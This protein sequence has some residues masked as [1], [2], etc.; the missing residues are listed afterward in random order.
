MLAQLGVKL[1]ADISSFTGE[2]KKASSAIDSFGNKVAGVGKIVSAGIS[3]PLVAAAGLSVKAFDT[4][5]QAEKR[6]EAALRSAGQFSQAALQDFKDF[7]SGL[8]SVTTVGDESTLKLLQVAKSMGL[9]N[10]QAKRAAKNSIALSKSMGINEQSA[11]RYTAALEQGD[12]T[13]LNRYLPTL[14]QVEDDSERAAK[15]QELLGQMFGAATAEAQSGLG[16]L[17][18]IKNTFGDL[19]EEIGGI[20]LEYMQPFI[21][22]LK[23]LVDAFKNSSQETKEFITQVILIGSVAGPAIVALGLALKGLALAFAMLTSPITLVVGAIALVAAG[24]IY[25]MAN[26]DALKER[27][28]S[29]AWWKNALI[30]MVQFL[31]EHSPFGLIIEGIN[32]VL[33]FAGKNPI[34]NPFTALSEG[35]EEFKEVPPEFKND[36][37]SLSDTAKKVFNELTGLEFD[38]VFSID[39][40][41]EVDEKEIADST[42]GIAPSV[43]V[44]VGEDIIIEENFEELEGELE[45]LEQGFQNVE[46]RAIT[47]KDVLLDFKKPLQDAA[48]AFL[49]ASLTAFT[50]SLF[51]A[52]EFNT[53]ELELRK[54]TLEKQRQALQESLAQ[55]EISQREYALRMTLLNEEMLDLE[56]QINEARTDRFSTAMDAMKVAAGQAVKAILAEFAKLAIIKG[57]L[58]I[59]G[60]PTGGFG[61]FFKSGLEGMLPGKARG[62]PVFSGQPYMVGERGPELFMPNRSGSI[63]PNGQLMGS[64]T[65]MGTQAINLNGEFRIKGTD[66]VLTLA[67]ANYKLGR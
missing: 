33:E 65:G 59:M 8:Q 19:Q 14:R 56:T 35:L 50:Q 64:G 30:D 12:S 47:F 9:T 51:N 18:Q 32:S 40:D 10:E 15:A 53:K 7:A 24:F 36:L 55:Q 5:I 20:V 3:T 22:G 54:I 11:I 28:S 43:P 38:K 23:N 27:F 57:L 62:G 58:A 2:I 44:K 37:L 17:I 34:P 66:L 46:R 6:L 21:Q 63:V 45:K 4:Q 49:D 39:F 1:F 61:K 26:F 25:A 41:L 52:G 13:M 42:K 48:T 31:L 16:P 29:I 60:T 67:E